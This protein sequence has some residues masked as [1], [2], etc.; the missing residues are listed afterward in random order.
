VDALG[1]NT[2]VGTLAT[3]LES[4]LL[5]CCQR[6]ERMS[7][8]GAYGLSELLRTVVGALG[9]GGGALVSRVTRDTHDCGFCEGRDSQVVSWMI[10]N[11]RGERRR[12]EEKLN[13][14]DIRDRQ[15]SISSK[16]WI[17]SF[18]FSSSGTNPM[19]LAL[20]RQSNWRLW[21]E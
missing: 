8:N 9:T 19:M 14:L 11:E 21:E 18:F 20:T 3:S 16:Q 4:A 2:G 17:E 13:Q 10:F 7:R 6:S 1:A 12:G 5:P 15:E